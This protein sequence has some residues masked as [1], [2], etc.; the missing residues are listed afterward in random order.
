MEK[1][2]KKEKI[3]NKYYKRWHEYCKSEAPIKLKK[4]GKI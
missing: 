4:N 3:I 2:E 1:K